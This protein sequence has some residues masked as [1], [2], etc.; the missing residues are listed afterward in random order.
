VVKKVSESRKSEVQAV[1][2]EKVAAGENGVDGDNGVD[3]EKS[4]DEGAINLAIPED[5][6]I[7]LDIPGIKF[8]LN[9]SELL[10]QALRLNQK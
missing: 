9:I 2:E 6:A 5:L 7:N 8:N 10:Q 4:T 1:E 3:G